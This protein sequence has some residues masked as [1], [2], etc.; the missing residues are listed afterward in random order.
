MVI[1]CTSEDVF[2][3]SVFYPLAVSYFRL[4]LAVPSI[5]AW[6][7]AWSVF[8]R[9]PGEGPPE[10]HH[11]SLAVFPSLIGLLA[12]TSE[13]L[14]AVGVALAIHLWAPLCKKHL[15]VRAWECR[16][17]MPGGLLG[18]ACRPRD[19]KPLP[20]HRKP[21]T[22]RDGSPFLFP[23]SCHCFPSLRFFVKLD[24]GEYAEILP[25]SKPE[26]GVTKCKLLIQMNA[27]QMKK[28]QSY[29]T[30]WQNDAYKYLI[31]H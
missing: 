18:S 10:E 27:A 9:T 17:A 25:K 16:L 26:E 20:S 14:E 1:W 8:H 30:Q 5:N 21:S 22:M 15:L 2:C 24:L 12:F 23:E 7:H 31:R 13:V 11:Q 29:L 3:A 4:S 6:I 28:N 19:Q